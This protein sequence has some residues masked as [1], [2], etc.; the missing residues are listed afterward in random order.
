MDVAPLLTSKINMK[1]LIAA[2]VAAA[3]L[4]PLASQAQQSY[5]GVN[6]GRSELKT[7]AGIFGNEETDIGYK[8]YVGHQFNPTF[9]IEGGYVW[10]GEIDTPLSGIVAS[11]KVRSI[12][13]A[14]TAT[15]PLNAQ[16]SLFGKLGVAHHRVEYGV[17]GDYG[18]T[19][20]TNRAF[21]GVGVAYAFT[22]TVSGVLEYDH[23]GRASK[24]GFRIKANLLSVGIRASF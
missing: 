8:A 11:T 5:V 24:D 10:L 21:A 13:L 4:A 14:G 15:A 18:D 23:F 1:K 20:S 3:A 19:E 6:V 2:V 9:G 22:P 12:Y 17:F 16:F 7:E